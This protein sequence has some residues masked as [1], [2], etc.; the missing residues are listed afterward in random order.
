VK[1]ESEVTNTQ[2]YVVTHTCAN[3]STELFTR[4]FINSSLQQ[5]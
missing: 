5:E 4:Q 3:E 1:H 2:E